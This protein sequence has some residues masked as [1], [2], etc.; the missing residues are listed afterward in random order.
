MT[1]RCLELC[2]KEQE[3]T[4]SSSFSTPVH[5]GAMGCGESSELVS[6][7]RSCTVWALKL[8]NSPGAQRKVGESTGGRWNMMK[9]LGASWSPN[10]PSS[11]ILHGLEA[12]RFLQL[13]HFFLENSWSSLVMSSRLHHK[14]SV[15]HKSRWS[16]DSDL[17]IFW[18]LGCWGSGG[19]LLNLPESQGEGILSLV[20]KPKK[21]GIYGCSISQMI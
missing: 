14:W 17:R 18:G 3:Q 20:V 11:H 6:Q 13:L 7:H 19:G 12:R 8:Y 16:R 5:H 2:T 21:A 15:H 9:L 1:V 10:N 4:G